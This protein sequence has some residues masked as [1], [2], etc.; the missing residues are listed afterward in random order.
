MG[1]S[2]VYC[3]WDGLEEKP[4]FASVIMAGG[5][6]T[7]FWPLSRRSLPKQFLPVPPRAGSVGAEETLISAT[8]KRM[9]QLRGLKS[10]ASLVDS[11]RMGSCTLIVTGKDHFELVRD[12]LPHVSVLGE[13]IGRNT[14]PCAVYAARFILDNLGDIPMLML[15]ADH[16]VGNE[17]EL[18]RLYS[19]ALEIVKS[20]D[21]LLTIGIRPVFPEVGYGY[22]QRGENLL[23][24]AGGVMSGA[25]KVRRFVEK[26]DYT[27]AE[28]YVKS[29]Q[30]YWNSGMFAWRP[31]VFL[32]EVE[33]HLPELANQMSR[34]SECWPVG[35][36]Q[37]I[38]TLPQSDAPST[39]KFATVAQEVFQAISPIS[40]DVGIMEKARNVV[41]L[42]ESG[43]AI[44]WSDVGSWS[45]WAEAA[46]GISAEANVV[47][48]E[49]ALLLESSGCVVVG[50]KRLISG[51]G[52]KDL[53][54]ID[55]PDALLVIPK[56]RT[57]EVR[58][59]V[60][61]LRAQGRFDLL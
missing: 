45:A 32:R 5:Q 28:G 57:Q 41:M 37:C 22:I 44:E 6:G 38:S 34:L 16:L 9:A 61:E 24:S 39:E 40:I 49:Q 33:R 58:T 3:N 11:E 19:A 14:A 15:P 60:D 7:R 10:G 31:S 2:L 35:Q 51:I 59:I 12:R 4:A 26:P 30:Y 17:A 47:H 8:V 20:Q 42:E 43:E 54:I 55:T 25:Y 29:G 1:S 23:D 53:V 36:R 50:G 46:K 56:D 48:A 52:L 27:T 18:L 13:P 21:V